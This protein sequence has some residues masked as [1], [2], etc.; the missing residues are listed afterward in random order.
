MY[1][2]TLKLFRLCPDDTLNIPKHRVQ[3]KWIVKTAKKYIWSHLF[4]NFT[5]VS[6]T[7]FFVKFD[8]Y[9]CSNQDEH[10]D[11]SRRQH[12]NIVSLV[13]TPGTREQKTP[14]TQWCFPHY[15][16]PIG[17]VYRPTIWSITF[18]CF[19][20]L[21]VKVW[22]GFSLPFDLPTILRVMFTIDTVFAV[23]VV[24]GPAT[25]W[26]LVVYDQSGWVAGVYRQPNRWIIILRECLMVV[27]FNGT[28][29]I[30]GILI[31]IFEVSV[32]EELK[33]FQAPQFCT[34]LLKSLLTHFLVKTYSKKTTIESK[35]FATNTKLYL[36]DLLVF[37]M[38]QF[39]LNNFWYFHIIL[40]GNNFYIHDD[41]QNDFC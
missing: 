6:S 26:Q 15:H 9:V 28:R 11:C 31:V 7:D 30:S 23:V 1:K 37:A 4:K 38:K 2:S 20:S 25:V 12:R 35:V 29:Q 33:R 41:Q 39:Y 22:S 18:S 24:I 3:L 32:F 21:R 27:G 10:F 17:V 19:A 16:H 14:L 5:M 13:Q 8:N 36:F 40:Y 34:N